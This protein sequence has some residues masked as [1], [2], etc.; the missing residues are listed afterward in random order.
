MILSQKRV[1]D[2]V[3]LS[4]GD[5]RVDAN[6]FTVLHE[7]VCAL[8]EGGNCKLVLDLSSVLFMD[9]CGL[10]GLIPTAHEIAPGGCFML[11]GLHPRLAQIFRLTGLDTLFDIY[12]SVDEALMT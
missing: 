3:V 8:A 9:S 11:T 6:N 5:S 7:H 12:S 2:F 10:A 4:V 1:G